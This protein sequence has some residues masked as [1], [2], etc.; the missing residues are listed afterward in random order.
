[1]RKKLPTKELLKDKAYTDIKELLVIGELAPGDVI[2]EGDLSEEL[3]MSRT[4]IRSAIQRLEHEGIVRVHSKQGIYI[5]DISIQQVNEIYEA[6]TLLE[7]FAIKKLS[8]TITQSQIQEL[9]NILNR[10]YEEIK[11]NNIQL[12]LE[13]DTKFHL[14]LMELMGNKEILDMFKSIETKLSFYGKRVLI[15]K[16]ERTLETYNEHILILNELEKGNVDLAVCYMK[17]HL[18]KGRRVLLNL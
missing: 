16:T 17:E 10:Q 1:M 18:E 6:R 4:P 11:N 2:S 8:K 13:F 3:G 9:K 12:Y 14:R 5:C 7:S 15:K